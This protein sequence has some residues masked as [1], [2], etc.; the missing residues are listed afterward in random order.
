MKKN[1]PLS[2]MR[3]C[4][5]NLTHPSTHKRLYQVILLVISDGMASL[6]AAS[7]IAQSCMRLFNV[8]AGWP[9]PPLPF[10]GNRDV[11]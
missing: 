11:Y 6:F 8:A 1:P 4:I 2:Q 5:N 9:C 3:G 7:E 10:K